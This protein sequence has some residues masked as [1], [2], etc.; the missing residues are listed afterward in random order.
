MTNWRREGLIK[1][2]TGKSFPRH[3]MFMDCETFVITAEDDSVSFPLRLGVAIYIELS[4]DRT[5][6]RQRQRVFYSTDDFIVFCLECIRSKQTLNIFGHNIGFDVRVLEL[7]EWLRDNG[8]ESEP[9]IINQRVFIWSASH[10]KRKLRFLDTANYGVISV[11]QLGKDL[12]LPKQSVDFEDVPD[13]KLI[14]YCIR[15]VEI[16]KTFILS[17]IDFLQSNN[18][19]S[20]RTTLASQSLTAWRSRFMQSSVYTHNDE[21][22]LR[23]ERNGYHGG[24]T[25]IFYQGYLNST[26]YFYYDVNSIYPYV[27]ANTMLPTY[28]VSYMVNPTIQSLAHVMEDYYLIADCL[29]ET[30]TAIYPKR[31]KDKLVFP[32]GEFR[33]VLHHTELMA[34]LS[35]GHVKT[36]YQLGVYQAAYVFKSYVEFFYQLKVNATNDHNKTLRYMTKLFLN[37]L[38]GKFGQL[39]PVRRH[40]ATIE[41]SIIYRIPHI[42]METG[43][44]YDELCWFGDIYLEYRH[45]EATYSAPAVAGAVTANA[46]ML[47]FK[48]YEIA[49]PDNVYYCDTDSLIVNATGHNNLQPYIDPTEIG[50]LKLEETANSV[51]I[52]GAKDYRFGDIVKVKGVPKKAITTKDGGWRYLQFQGFITWLNEGGQGP[53]LGWQR[54]KHRRGSYTKGEV[55]ADG[56]VIPL[57]FRY[58]PDH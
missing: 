20:F 52:F 57:R 30:D 38:Y 49:G 19:G 5:I 6:K 14:D 13:D 15:D 56:R 50:K 58:R 37:S 22:L 44:R 34:A 47:L 43:L 55:L 16:I 36:I 21:D 26:N 10:N 53:P 1:P 39:Q 40:V 12:G 32:I 4:A 8:W 17:Y 54:T 41:D 9:P 27:M 18:L 48:Y 28:P 46:R 29:L 45:G 35:R 33:T 25:E 24:R 7:P 42:D 11:D 23:L 31:H 2:L 3:L 51:E